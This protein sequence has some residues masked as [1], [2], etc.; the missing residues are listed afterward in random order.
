MNINQDNLANIKKYKVKVRFIKDYKVYDESFIGVRVTDVFD[1]LDIKNYESA[2][3][4]CKAGL[5]VK[6]IKKDM[7]ENKFLAFNIDDKDLTENE[8]V[9]LI[10]PDMDTSYSIPNVTEIYFQ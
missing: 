7:N 9:A 5:M 6:Y 2:T 3:F 1:S 8:L 10:S 4:Q